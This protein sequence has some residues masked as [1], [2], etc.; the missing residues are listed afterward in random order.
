[1]A[2]SKIPKVKREQY[3]VIPKK[4]KIEESKLLFSFEL[5]DFSVEYY[6]CN[7]MCDKGIKNCFEKLRDYSR[8]TVDEIHAGRGGDTIRFHQ[9]RKA[10]VNEWPNYLENNEELEE[11]F[12]QIS[13]G[14]SNGRAHGIIIENKF[15]IIWLDP[16]HYLYHDSRYGPKQGFT[17]LE[18]CCTPRDKIIK[19][20]EKRI[21]DLEQANREYIELLDTVTK[22]NI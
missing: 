8:F 11:S 3:N 17:E 1:M 6:N 22:P 14:R 12:Y 7:G 21:E 9:I 19:S 20:Y 5:L 4:K 15:Y 13:F 2:L 10:D 16:H 18:N